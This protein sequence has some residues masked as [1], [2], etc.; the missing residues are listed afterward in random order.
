VPADVPPLLTGVRYS[1][2]RGGLTR[3]GCHE[4]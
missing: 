4:R 1:V 2:A 3:A